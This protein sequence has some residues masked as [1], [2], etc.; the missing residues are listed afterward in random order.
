MKAY[1]ITAIAVSLGLL[2]LP[3]VGLADYNTVILGSGSVISIAGY[4][5]TGDVGA[6]VESLNVDTNTFTVSIPPSS[7]LNLTS[8]DSKTLQVS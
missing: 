2:G 1:K 3:I 8:A 7:T 6:S 5:F 4:N